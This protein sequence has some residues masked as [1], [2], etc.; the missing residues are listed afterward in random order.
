MDYAQ[1]PGRHELHRGDGTSPEQDEPLGD[2]RSASSE[3]GQ[4]YALGLI[5]ENNKKMIVSKGIGVSILAFRFMCRPEI[6][7]VE[8]E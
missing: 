4:K 8:F 5:E 2:K 1:I 6:V 7:V 3:Y